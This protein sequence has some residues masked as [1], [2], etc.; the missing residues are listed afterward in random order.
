M[1]P[2]PAHTGLKRICSSKWT[3][4]LA[5]VFSELHLLNFDSKRE[6]PY[7]PAGTYNQ[8]STLFM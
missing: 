6:I 3:F 4:Q 5:A 8:F 2:E 1:K 7:G